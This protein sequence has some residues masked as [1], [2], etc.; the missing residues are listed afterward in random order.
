MSNTL[1]VL[2]DTVEENAIDS[3]AEKTVALLIK[4]SLSNLE[5]KN[6]LR[7]IQIN[8]DDDLINVMEKILSVSPDM[9]ENIEKSVNEIVK[10]GKIDSKDVPQLIIVV[11]QIYQIIYS[12]KNKKFDAEKRAELAG[13]VLKY[14]I[15]ALV[16]L[17]KIKIEHSKEEQFVN[18]CDLLIDACIGLLSFPKKIKTK[19]CIKKLFG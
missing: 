5:M 8:L 3:L 13:S 2:I 19:G 6:K 14:C 18:D 16:V 4:N 17:D 10:D 7:K 11:K 9:F 12:L 15:R 1:D